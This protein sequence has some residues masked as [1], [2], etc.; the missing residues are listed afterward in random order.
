V[1]KS[2]GR[3]VSYVNS[4][5]LAR[6]TN[7]VEDTLRNLLGKFYVVDENSTIQYEEYIAPPEEFESEVMTSDTTKNPFLS[8]KFKTNVEDAEREQESL[9]FATNTEETFFDHHFK[10]ILPINLSLLEKVNKVG[11]AKYVDMNPTYNFYV[12][13]YESLLRENGGIKENVL[14]NFYSIYSEGVYDQ[15]DVTK[16]NSLDGN[17][18]TDLRAEFLSVMGKEEENIVDR[19]AEYYK[20]FSE[21]ANIIIKKKDIVSDEEDSRDGLTILN[22]IS[23]GYDTFVFTDSSI[24]LLTTEASKAQSFPMYN[25]IKFST[26]KNTA[27]ANILRELKLGV[28]IIN[29]IRATPPSDVLFGS[30]K[31][32][33]IPAPQEDTAPQEISTY[34]EEQLRTWNV[35]EWIVDRIFEDPDAGLKIGKRQDRPNQANGAIQELFTKMILGAKV[36]RLSKNKSRTYEQMMAGKSCYSEAVFYKITKYSSKDPITPI[37]TYYVPNSGDLDVCRIIDTQVKYGK[38]YR[39]T[40]MSYV[41]VMGS[42]YKY[43]KINRGPNGTTNFTPIVNPSIMLMEM[44]FHVAE[45]MLVLDSPPMAPEVSIVPFKNVDNKVLINFNGATGDRVLLPVE[46]NSRDK[47]IINLLRQSQKRGDAKLRFKSDDA[48]TLFEIYRMDTPPKSYRDFEGKKIAEAST[49]NI[50]TSAAFKDTI[51]PNMKYYYTFRVK[52]IHNHF[53]NP[54]IVYELEMKKDSSAPFL[55]VSAFDMSTEKENKNQAPSKKMRRYVQI[56]PT[57]PQGLLNVSNSQLLNVKTVKNVTSVV[58]GV[59]NEKLWGRKFRVRFTSKKT[60]RK[61]DLDVNFTVE[62]KL[63]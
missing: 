58:L 55:S 35:K 39:Y 44:P 63:K 60:G 34:K 20:Q 32:E 4:T 42:Q 6:G 33:Y 51:T 9:G 18:D 10:R 62:H 31:Q 50:A 17:F 22:D 23:D 38:G 1:T 28:D 15:S 53:S 25:E 5:L 19:Y 3:N 43:Q 7:V 49:D 40:I 21:S 41:L 11:V 46:I 12:P 14:P 61:I 52:D 27:F 36:N 30:S 13:P 57:V 24:P 47:I 59:A 48:P 56:I 26:D 2:F 16:I 8:V 29:F 37:T 45:N 54:T